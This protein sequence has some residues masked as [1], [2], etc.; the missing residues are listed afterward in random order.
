ALHEVLRIEVR[1]RGI[2]RAGGMDD[3]ERLLLEIGR[4]RLKRRMESEEAIE[5]DDAIARNRDRRPRRVV[6]L[7]AVRHHDVQSVD[8]AALEDRDEN[9]ASLRRRSVR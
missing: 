5:I 3:R 8:G 7:L 9:L 2:G 4:E 6:R 1:A